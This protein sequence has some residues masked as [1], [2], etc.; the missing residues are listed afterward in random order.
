MQRGLRR[1]GRP[2]HR[3][4]RH[5][6]DDHLGAL[7]ER[8]PV[9]LGGQR[10]HVPA[11]PGGVVDEQCRALVVGEVLGLGVEERVHR[12]LGVDDQDL[13]AG[14]PHD[15]VGS[16]AAVV[17][18]DRGDL[19][20]EVAARQHPGRLQDPPQ[21]HLAPGAAD[22]RRPQRAGQRRGLPTEVLG[23]ALDPGQQGPQRAELLH[24]VALERADVGLDAHERVLERRQQGGGLHVFG[25]R[26]LEVEHPLTQQVALGDDGGR[27]R[28]VQQAAHRHRDAD[29]DD[30]THEAPHRCVHGVTIPPGT[31]NDDD[32]PRHAD[33]PRRGSAR[34]GTS[35]APS[36]PR[37]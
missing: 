1:Q 16:D 30:Q 11:Q 33:R 28:G 32:I 6:A 2:E 24:P 8:R 15:D 17:G 21:L 27:A 25:Q 18:T 12:R 19:L 34:R 10:G 14:Q 26:G 35:T 3:V 29:A 36:G 4:A 31:D 37:G 13:A 7:A 22:G 5:E 20:V 9:L 23:L